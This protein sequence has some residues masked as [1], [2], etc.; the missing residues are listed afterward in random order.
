[1]TIAQ[2]PQGKVVE[3]ELTDKQKRILLTH[4]SL[5]MPLPFKAETLNTWQRLI[6]DQ[7]PL[8]VAESELRCFVNSVEVNLFVGE[9][10]VELFRYPG[11]GRIGKPD[12]GRL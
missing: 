5:L 4:G 8:S 3:I 9:I 7:N 11:N 2:I 6:Y 1:M 10:K 12:D